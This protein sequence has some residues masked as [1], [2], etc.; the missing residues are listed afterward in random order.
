MFGVGALETLL[1]A[2]PV[3]LV[4]A[5]IVSVFIL[6]W[7]MWRLSSDIGAIRDAVE[8]IADCLEAQWRD[9]AGKGGGQARAGNSGPGVA[10]QA[11]AR[12]AAAS[13]KPDRAP[14]RA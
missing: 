14:H 8:Y 7:R 13:G 1:L 9:Q 6:A 4:V 10:A 12:L 3:L 11:A 2:L 5:F